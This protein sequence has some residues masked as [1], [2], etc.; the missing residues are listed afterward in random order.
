MF[1]ECSV[2]CVGVWDM[3]VTIHTDVYTYIHAQMAF[4]C[5]GVASLLTYTFLAVLMHSCVPLCA[6]S[7]QDH[8]AVCAA[9]QRE[10]TPGQHLHCGGGRQQV[11]V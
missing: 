9:R 4:M 11:G 2:R 8:P 1:H 10:H 6:G 5:M 7:W 3:L